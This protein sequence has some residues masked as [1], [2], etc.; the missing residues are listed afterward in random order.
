MSNWVISAPGVSQPEMRS[1]GEE[2]A[3]QWL[4]PPS[5][6]ANAPGNPYCETFIG[7]FI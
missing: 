2:Q 6:P 1:T 5:L 3:P 7:I 4:G